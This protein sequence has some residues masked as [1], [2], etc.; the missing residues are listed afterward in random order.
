MFENLS[1]V[2]KKNES[3]LFIGP[4]FSGKFGIPTL[5]VIAQVL[6]EKFGISEGTQDNINLIV[7]EIENQYEDGRK[8]IVE[9]VYNLLE[10]ISAA[11]EHIF[12]IPKIRWKAIYTWKFDTLIEKAFEISSDIALQKLIVITDATET[13]SIN[14]KDS[15]CLFKLNGCIRNPLNPKS[16]LVLTRQDSAFTEGNRL[17]LLS[18]VK[19]I[20]PPMNFIFVG[21]RLDETLL[22]IIALV[23]EY[24][25]KTFD[26]FV[27]S[28]TN[29]DRIFER[30][31][32]NL[33]A[34][35]ISMDIDAFFSILMQIVPSEIPLRQKEKEVTA[36]ISTQLDLVE[37]NY[38]DYKKYSSQLLIY[39]EHEFENNRKINK[40]KPAK[41]FYEGEE[42]WLSGL[43]KKIPIERDVLKRLIGPVERDLNR[44]S[45]TS[46]KF[47][48]NIFAILYDHPGAG[49]TTVLKTLGYK[50]YE[51]K[52]NPVFMIKPIRKSNRLN[53]DSIVRFCE[54][55]YTKPL[56]LIDNVSMEKDNF[57]FL[58]TLFESRRTPATFV[59]CSRQEEWEE[60]YYIDLSYFTDENSVIMEEEKELKDL[61]D[62]KTLSL[63][64][65]GLKGKAKLFPLYENLKQTEKQELFSNIIKT[66]SI[67][68]TKIGITK[69]GID[70]ETWKT[71]YDDDILLVLLYKIFKNA[72]FEIAI[73]D[74]YRALEKKDSAAAYCYKIICALDALKL[75]MSWELLRRILNCD[76]NYILNLKSI[77]GNIVKPD[78][79]METNL[80]KAR[81]Q[82]IA[83]KLFEILYDK[84]EKK[85]GIFTTII[86]NISANNEYQRNL[87]RQII[88]NKKLHDELGQISFSNKIFEAARKVVPYDPVVI[89]HLGITFMKMGMEE[90]A[91]AAFKEAL[92]YYPENPAVYNSQG[93][94][95]EQ[96]AFR[97][98]NAPEPDTVKAN[99][100]FQKAHEAF[101]KSINYGR[102]AE[103]GY[104]RYGRFL[105]K[106]GRYYEKNST[107]WQEIIGKIRGLIEDARD[108]VSEI[109]LIAIDNLQGRL[110]EE[111]GDMDAAISIYKNILTHEKSNHNV[112][113]N[114][115]WIYF[116]KEN[117]LE[118]INILKP[119]IDEEVKEFR[120]YKLYSR[121]IRL[122]YPEK[123]S[124]LLSILLKAHNIDT[125][126]L[127]IN[128]QLG[129]VYYKLGDLSK[130]FPF[131]RNCDILSYK[132]PDR[133]KTLTMFEEEGKKKEFYGNVKKIIHENRGYVTRDIYNDDLFFNPSRNLKVHEGDRVKFNIGFC[134]VGPQA[135]DLRKAI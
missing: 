109:R 64:E 34:Q 94:L 80:F 58:Y 71:Q 112:R 85:L 43:E 90:Q 60:D 3:I 46:G 67:D 15:V 92:K 29:H 8:R 4:E 10:S 13:F 1:N 53:F 86:E 18:F 134:F 51:K 110:N 38:D 57:K 118:A 82:V 69:I 2:I 127:D 89:Q 97:F 135:L 75:K 129:V 9:E 37:I 23:Q 72:R 12:S 93:I 63:K 66:Q 55:F 11:S 40:D 41:D 114:L 88:L 77:F 25:Y 83:E 61:T 20:Y 47:R 21:F 107:D 130:A 54:K 87:L 98:M 6:S 32:K 125:E 14:D 48:N 108:N 73:I 52:T 36:M 81:H 105:F 49:G 117:Y 104:D 17:T 7:S 33:R 111:T 62:L 126:D 95:Y 28:S 70:F 50:I 39:C 79:E 121:L 99:I 78:F 45:D 59:V 31:L 123:L 91:E 26:V 24:T 124:E 42:I 102:D 119:S 131:F 106:L 116:K 100:Y 103:H 68:I 56:I 27:V 133:F 122:K 35:L 113:Y 132:R 74:E 16:K 128:F 84:P 30:E 120:F 76:W 44:H 65:I 101:Q 22:N 5:Q 19:D 96:I 115:A